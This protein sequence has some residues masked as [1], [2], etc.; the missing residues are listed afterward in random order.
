MSTYLNPYNAY[1]GIMLI[2]L[3]PPIGLAALI[4]FVSAL[5]LFSSTM[6]KR[7]FEVE[8]NR[9]AYKALDASANAGNGLINEFNNGLNDIIQTLYESPLNTIW[10][11]LFGDGPP[12]PAPP[13]L[14]RKSADDFKASLKRAGITV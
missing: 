12:N 11:L 4:L 2:A 14:Y 9:L 8:I 6:F 7:K 10:K 1:A 3:I 5:L 13:N